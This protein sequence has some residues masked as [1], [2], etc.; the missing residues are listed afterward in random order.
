ML[1]KRISFKGKIKDA[2][3]PDGVSV[4]GSDLVFQGYDSQQVKDIC[5]RMSGLVGN[6]SRTKYKATDLD[7]QMIESMIDTESVD[8]ASFGIYRAVVSSTQTDTSNDKF[9]VEVLNEM[10]QQY[11]DGRTVVLGHDMYSAVGKTFDAEVVASEG[12]HELFVKFYV[13]PGLQT[14]TGGEVKTMLDV[15][16]YDRFSIGAFMKITHSVRDE[17]TGIR[18]YF[19]DH[20]NVVVAHLGIVDMGANTDAMSK[21]ASGAGLSFGEIKEEQNEFPKMKF[22]KTYKS[23]GNVSVSLEP[24]AVEALLDQ[25]EKE[26]STLNEKVKEIETKEAAALSKLR[27]EWSACKKQLDTAADAEKIQKRADLL[28]AEILEE[29]IAEMKKQILK[30]K[31][32]LDTNGGEE[33]KGSSLQIFI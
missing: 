28:T 15:G 16:A 22:E 12:G 7:R 18:E 26:I 24:E 4:D 6:A 25:V 29:D 21:S 2:I 1:R 14:S 23:L 33:T 10:G 3:L 8:V 13:L 11:K 17:E 31:N 9:S 5:K 20:N 30:K 19:Y 32:Q 27:D